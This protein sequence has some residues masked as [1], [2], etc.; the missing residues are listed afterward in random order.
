MKKLIALLA[1][2]LLFA[3]CSTSREF[4]YSIPEDSRLPYSETVDVPGESATDIYKKFRL[5]IVDRYGYM[6]GRS[7]ATK[8]DQ[9][10]FSINAGRLPGYSFRQS[11][12]IVVTM[13]Y[14]RCRINYLAND[15]LLASNKKEFKENLSRRDADWRSFTAELKKTLL[16]S[17]PTEDEF[18]KLMEDGYTEYE[19]AKYVNAQ[20]YFYRALTANPDDID[21]LTSYGNCLAEMGNN[22]AAKN[23]WSEYFAAT[24]YFDAAKYIYGLM[25][26]NSIAEG[27]IRICENLQKEAAQRMQAIQRQREEEQRQQNAA[28]WLA[29]AESMNALASSISAIQGNKS[30]GAYSG[31]YNDSSGNSADDSSGKQ[32]GKD[33][34]IANNPTLAQRTYTNYERAA[35]DNIKNIENAVK[36]GEPSHRIRELERSLSDT[37]KKMKEYRE[38]AK[39][40]GV[41]I[42]QSSYETAK[43]RY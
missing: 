30:G 9:I 8:D 36:S 32:H 23:N 14:E 29:V 13:E 22:M 5:F 25:P 33:H 3:A 35:K 34:S 16:A 41:D 1:A 18:F 28:N 27:N 40:Q 10:N 43:P 31:Q 38:R 20:K 4:K 24:R 6:Y 7:I 42:R 15:Y 11:E 39:Q 17:P 12:D 26:G 19:N 2:V 21:A 37:Q